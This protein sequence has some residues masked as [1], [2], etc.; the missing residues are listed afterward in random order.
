MSLSSAPATP[1]A[2]SSVP[3]GFSDRAAISIWANRTTSSGSTPAAARSAAGEATSA[4]TSLTAERYQPT[5][6]GLSLWPVPPRLRWV[7]VERAHP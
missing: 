7:D 6:A 5:V 1:T 3:P 4:C 2:S